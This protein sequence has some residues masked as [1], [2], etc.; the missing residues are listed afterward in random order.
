MADNSCSTDVLLRSKSK[1]E[2]ITKSPNTSII[3]NKMGHIN[4]NVIELY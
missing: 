4:S 1:E 2:I 3:A